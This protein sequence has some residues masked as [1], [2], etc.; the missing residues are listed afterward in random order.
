MTNQETPNN[1]SV[2]N[3][4]IMSL[5]LHES[6][7]Q[8]TLA[9]ITMPVRLVL[10][11]IKPSVDISR[12]SQQIKSIFPAATVILASS[13]GLLCSRMGESILNNLYGNGLEGGDLTLLLMSNKIIN[14]IHIATV[15]LGKEIPNPKD[16]IAAIER[17]VE[18]ISIPFKISHQDTLAYTLVD[19][20]SGAESFLMEAIYDSP[21]GGWRCPLCRWKCWR[22]IRLSEHLYF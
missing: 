7:I 4:D 6:A 16:Q 15:K 10:G 5:Y 19:G 1:Q 20:L 11:F 17:E 13:A 3:Q 8:S 9:K 14:N 21:K 18:R 22:K 2:A 12:A